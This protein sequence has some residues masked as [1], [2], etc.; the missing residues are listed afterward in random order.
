VNGVDSDSAD[1][2]DSAEQTAAAAQRAP[3]S[4]RFQV[5]LS[6][7][8]SVDSLSN[9]R[10]ED[11]VRSSDRPKPIGHDGAAQAKRRPVTH[12]KKR[13]KVDKDKVSDDDDEESR[14]RRL[15]TPSSSRRQ[16]ATQL[17]I[18]SYAVIKQ[19]RQFRLRSRKPLE[20]RSP[21]ILS[22]SPVRRNS[23]CNAT[24]NGGLRH[25]D[26]GRRRSVDVGKNEADAQEEA[27]A[28]KKVSFS[29]SGNPAAPAPGGLH[30]TLST[31]VLRIKHRRSFWEKVIG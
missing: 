23:T 27:A 21:S 28:N 4:A 15:S 24:E 30:R 1:M 25:L 18:P 14:C 16:S 5:G 8:E 19:D 7:G 22:C 31:S 11:A 2:A 13:H 3:A 6:S 9:M 10:E 29:S 20:V 26:A 12:R 17:T